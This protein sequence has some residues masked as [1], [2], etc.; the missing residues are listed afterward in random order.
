MS[1]E[2]QDLD[3][4]VPWPVDDYMTPASKRGPPPFDFERLIRFMGY[5][6]MMAPVQHK[7]F[8]FLQRLFPIENGKGTANAFRRVAFDQFIFAPIGM[9]L[10][11]FELA[12]AMLIIYRSCGLFHIHD[13]GRGWWKESSNPEVPGR[14]PALAQSQLYR[15]AAGPGA[16]LPGHSNPVPNRESMSIVV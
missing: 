3:R 12:R 7:W 9:W 11:G 8:G 4:K 15:M 5:G 16:E 1:V 2:I 13:C 6:F 10:R 14:L